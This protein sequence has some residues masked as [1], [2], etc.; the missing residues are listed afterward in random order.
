MFANYLCYVNSV[1]VYRSGGTTRV[2]GVMLALGTFGLLLLGPGVIQYLPVMVVAA[3]IFVLGIDLS[4]EALW[5][6]IGRVSREEYITIVII[7][8]V[9]TYADFVVGIIAG[10]VFAC[11][12]F[13]LQASRRRNTIR[14][15]FDGSIA[16]STVRR[17]I[18]QRRFLEQVGTQTQILKLQGFLFFGTI[19]S[20]EDL[21]RRALDIATW[22][23]NP[24]RFLIVDFSLVSGVDFS[25]AEAFTRV[26]RLLEAKDVVLVFCGLQPDS[27]VGVAL[28]SVGLWTDSDLRLEVFANLNEA[29]EWTENEFL[30]GMYSSGWASAQAF[31][32]A[33]AGAG[34][35]GMELRRSHSSTSST[36]AA[37]GDIGSHKPPAGGG[38]VPGVGLEAAGLDI[39]D[40]KG[41][42]P[43]FVLDSGFENSPRRHHLQQAVR[44]A[45][46]RAGGDAMM[47]GALSSVPE[48]ES[49][50]VSSADGDSE[51]GAD[52]GKMER[53]MGSSGEQLPP[54]A[55]PQP[56]HGSDSA[57]SPSQAASVQ[58]RRRLV[59]PLPLL[60]LTFKAY[61]QEDLGPDF[62]A[63]LAPYFS[64]VHISKGQRLWERGDEP[65][66]L[67]LIEKGILKARYDFPQE[68]FEINE[69]MLAGTIAGELSF[70]SGQIRNT[71]VHAELDCVLWKLDGVNLDRMQ[72]ERPARE[73]STFFR[74]LL[75]VTEEEQECLMSYL[76]T[77]L[78]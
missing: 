63:N 37:P 24:I 21:I 40:S 43:A 19:N 67:Y 16:R 28:R 53:R 56:G 73:F 45:L 75:R 61:A 70:L 32:R 52:R 49:G 1:L 66:G 14:A 48:M 60:M 9:S 78:S 13:V 36:H 74:M 64:K 51:A 58:R 8:A 72:A 10:L 29:L 69:A 17:H 20:V 55:L 25:A 11:L 34:S 35:S 33:T 71:S 38:A 5:D 4:K 39:P 26:Q 59:Q 57:P 6:T 76:V 7:V 3:L 22:Q 68:D 15:I 65:D 77:R 23:S 47:V 54:N 30:R 31:G 18:T 2:T 46:E 42:Q 41:R 44:T 50:D 62:F 27:D 12:F